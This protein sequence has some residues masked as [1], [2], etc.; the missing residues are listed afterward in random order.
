MTKL[1]IHNAAKNAVKVFLTFGASGP[2]CSNPVGVGDFPILSHIPN[3]PLQGTFT[4]EAGAT[5]QF[6]PKGRC[7][8]GNVGFFILPQCPVAGADFHHGKEGTN[9]GEFTLNVSGGVN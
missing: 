4:L 8:T 7:F 3:S 5:H 6:D 9:I 2:V 1:A